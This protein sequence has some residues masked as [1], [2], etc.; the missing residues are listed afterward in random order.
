[1]FFDVF[2]SFVYL[3]VCHQASSAHNRKALCSGEYVSALASSSESSSALLDSLLCYNN[4]RSYVHCEWTQAR[5][6]SVQLWF[7]RSKNR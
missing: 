4:Y 3:F 2:V 7:N 6:M 5:N 1:M